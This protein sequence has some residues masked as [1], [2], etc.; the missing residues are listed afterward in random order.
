M[1]M[2]H[3]VLVMSLSDLVPLVVVVVV[4]VDLLHNIFR[5]LE[6]TRTNRNLS[7]FNLLRFREVP[8][9]MGLRRLIPRFSGCLVEDL[10][11]AQDFRHLLVHRRNLK[12]R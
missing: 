10:L 3:W 7:N 8:L 2:A 1:G 11:P 12:L 4:V 5:T 6:Y 9:L